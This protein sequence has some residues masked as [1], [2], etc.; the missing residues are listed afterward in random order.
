MQPALKVGQRIET[1]WLPGRPWVGGHVEAVDH[2]G[3]YTI[4]LDDGY[5]SYRKTR[6]SLRPVSPE[7]V[8]LS[9]DCIDGAVP[10]TLKPDSA[11]PSILRVG[12]QVQRLDLWERVVPDEANR[13]TISREHCEIHI[14]SGTGDPT[15]MLKNLSKIGTRVNGTV[16]QRE[17]P[18]R[19]ADII[20]IGG[21]SLSD[22]RGVVQFCVVAGSPGKEAYRGSPTVASGVPEKG[23]TKPSPSDARSSAGSSAA[24][25]LFRLECIGAIGRHQ[26]EIQRMPEAERFLCASSQGVGSGSSL[27]VGRSIQPTRLWE[28]LVPEEKFRNK[29]SREHFEVQFSGKEVEKLGSEAALVS[30]SLAGTLVNG[31]RVHEPVALRTGDV[32]A[33]PFSNRP[34]EEGSPIVSFRLEKIP[35][36]RTARY[37][38]ASFGG[39]CPAALLECIAVSGRQHSEVL[40]LPEVARTLSF[41]EAEDFL[42]VGRAVQKLEWWE[43]LVPSETERAKVSR[44]H[45]KVRRLGGGRFEL[46]SLSAAGTVV[47]GSRVKD[48]VPLR[49]GDTVAVPSLP[50]SED[51]PVVIFRF[52]GPDAIGD[53]SINVGVEAAMHPLKTSPSGSAPLATLPL[54][55]APIPSPYEAL[56]GGH[57]APFELQCISVLGLSTAELGFLPKAT[58]VWLPSPGSVSLK[59]GRSVQPATLWATIVPD[60][61]L[62][63]TICREQFEITQETSTI[64]APTTYLKNLGS[65]P[66]L[67]NGQRVHDRTRLE[68]MDIIGIGS[69]PTDKSMPVLRFRF[70]LDH[71][72]VLASVTTLPANRDLGEHVTPITVPQ[73]HA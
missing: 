57:Q 27:R 36:R 64:H 15:F 37:G 54:G 50:N 23:P 22:L 2:E 60:E 29:I 20:G 25:D 39:E 35:S 48:K 41:S 28:L 53:R 43:Q 38:T 67:V 62:R 16:V 45:F 40:G 42:S 26:S 11:N 59:V 31:R 21:L 70:A 58:R 6:E 1:E 4:V 44:E 19:A 13:N 5:R 61:K 49:S 56:E 51:R 63:M 55:T 47:N 10:C 34:E 24:G 69:S 71:N 7:T 68:A 17:K 73:M 72:Q 12:R 8:K 46:E 52:Q 9:L 32:M 18:I 14:S 33:V 65:A 3:L 30:L 66:T